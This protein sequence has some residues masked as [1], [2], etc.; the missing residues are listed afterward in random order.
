[1]ASL[2]DEDAPL[3]CETQRHDPL[4][5][6]PIAG[7]DRVPGQR[8]RLIERAPVQRQLRVGERHKTVLGLLR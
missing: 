5:A 7:L 8:L 4:R 2:R 1:M 3:Q 6:V